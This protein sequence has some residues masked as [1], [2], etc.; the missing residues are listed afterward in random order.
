MYT[1]QPYC[2]NVRINKM[3]RKSM[4]DR[5]YDIKFITRVLVKFALNL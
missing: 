2:A 1:V 3:Q 5:K 4:S